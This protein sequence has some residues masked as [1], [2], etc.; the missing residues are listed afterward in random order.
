VNGEHY[1]VKHG[2]F[3]FLLVVAL[4]SLLLPI[5]GWKVFYLDFVGKEAPGSV[6][7][8]DDAVWS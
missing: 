8:V 4:F 1:V 7:M 5:G 2:L 3:A 6:R